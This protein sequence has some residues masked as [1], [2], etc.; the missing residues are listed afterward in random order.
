M[1]AR[2]KTVV[3]VKENG[4]TLEHLKPR[5]LKFPFF[6]KQDGYI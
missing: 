3:L 1:E 6:S 4:G 5:V 2:Q